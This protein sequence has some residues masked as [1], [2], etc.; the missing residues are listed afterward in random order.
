MPDLRAC[1]CKTYPSQ[2]P[3][4]P[5]DTL[6]KVHFDP[7]LLLLERLIPTA[8]EWDQYLVHDSGVC[9]VKVKKVCSSVL[10]EDNFV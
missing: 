2:A 10:V 9:M 6:T 3:N 5:S 8:C 1:E 7:F 4:Q